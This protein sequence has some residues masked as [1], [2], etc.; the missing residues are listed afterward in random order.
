MQLEIWDSLM[1]RFLR[2]KVKISNSKIVLIYKYQQSKVISRIRVILNKMMKANHH[3][4]KLQFHID[5]FHLTRVMRMRVSRTMRHHIRT[6]SNC[7]ILLA[8]NQH[9][10]SQIKV[11]SFHSNKSLL[12][13]PISRT[14][15]KTMK[16]QERHLV[17]LITRN[18]TLVIERLETIWKLK[19]LANSTVNC[20]GFHSFTQNETNLAV[21]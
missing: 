19:Y 21:I 10:I 16:Q 12:K 18:N 6:A 9:Q 8:L 5:Q 3:L 1:M 14:N 7:R 17:F 13:L 2:E 20:I 4:R 15:T 11:P